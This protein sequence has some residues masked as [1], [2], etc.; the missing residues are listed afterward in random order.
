MVNKRLSSSG[1]ENVLLHEPMLQYAEVTNQLADSSS[2]NCVFCVKVEA[3]PAFPAWFR[4]TTRC[5]LL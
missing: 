3:I 2:L 1:R 5:T 4:F